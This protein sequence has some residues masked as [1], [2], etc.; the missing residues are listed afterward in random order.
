MD[1]DSLIKELERRRIR[2]GSWKA[3]ALDLGVTQ[4]YVHDVKQRRRE[5]GPTFLAALGL[6]KVVSYV[7][8]KGCKR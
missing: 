2:L 6:V 3:V 5:P 4:Q 1:K 7:H 8:Q